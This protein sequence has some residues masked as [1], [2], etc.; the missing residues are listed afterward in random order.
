MKRILKIIFITLA[1][2]WIFQMFFR[3]DISRTSAK[4]MPAI[5]VIDRLTGKHHL[6]LPMTHFSL[7]PYPHKI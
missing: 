3:Y 1:C 2:L 5:S 6:F 4:R 7:F